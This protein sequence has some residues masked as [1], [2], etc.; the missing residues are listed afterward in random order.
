M[1]EEELFSQGHS[2]CA[3]CGSAL[4]IRYALKAAG[5]DTIVVQSTGCMEV[6]STATP[7]SAW[8]VPYIHTAFECGP[9]DA[10]GIDRALKKLGRRKNVN[11]LVFAGDGGTFDIG[12]QSLSGMIERGHKVCYVCNDNEAYMNTG[13][14][15]SGSTPKYAYTTTT[16]FGKKIHAK[17]EYKKP[18]PFILAAHR[19]PYVATASVA[20]PQDFVKKVKKALSQDGPSYVQIFS[21][22][23]PGWKYDPSQTIAIAKIAVETGVT[24]LYEIEHGKFILTKKFDKFNPVKEYYKTQGR[25]KGM[26]EKELT[27]MQKH[28]DNEW[29]FLLSKENDYF[30]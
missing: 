13:I 17:Q 6:I 21:P 10:S 8:Q 12:L 3:G 25:F 16:P 2:A 19:M 9:A 27:E 15:R 26:D 28:V 14:Q 30:F 18:L 29:K 1:S 4:A 24:P 20:Y 11:I 5:K 7:L 22:C 23:V